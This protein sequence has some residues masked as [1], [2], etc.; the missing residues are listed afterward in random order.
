MATDKIKKIGI[1]RSPKVSVGV[2]VKSDLLELEINVSEYG[3]DVLQK[4][5]GAYQKKKRYYRLES[6]EFVSLANEEFGT[7]S[8]M[9]EGYNYSLNK[10]PEIFYK[11]EA[12]SSIELTKTLRI[13]PTLINKH[14]A[15]SNSVDIEGKYIYIFSIYLYYILV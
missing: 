3:T 1:R 5:L 4:M 9:I 13:K 6:G 11:N 14:N 8:E 10:L 2:S 7:L 15:M 12:I